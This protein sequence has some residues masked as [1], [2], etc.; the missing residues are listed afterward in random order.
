V[1]GVIAVCL[2]EMVIK[3]FGIDK[4]G[5]L[6]IRAGETQDI[7]FLATGDVED[8]YV[9]DLIRAACGALNMSMQELADIFG[10]Y[11]INSFSQKVYGSLYRRHKTAEEFI[12]AIDTMHLHLTRNIDNASPPRF[13]YV[14]KDPK[15]LVMTYTSRRNMIDFVAGLIRGVGKYYQEDLLVSKI[16]DNTLE[17][18]FSER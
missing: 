15:T 4:W 16:N 1:K 6:L 10:E 9:M 5:D 14:W 2:K 7:S 8:R 13:E 17:V 11:W 18:I 12:L 3:K